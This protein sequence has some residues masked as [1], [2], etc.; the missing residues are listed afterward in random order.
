MLNEHKDTI[1]NDASGALRRARRVVVKVGSALLVDGNGAVNRAWLRKLGEDVAALRA[2]KTDVVI[3]TSG[4]IALG[5]RRLGLSGL[6]RLEESQAAS[7]AGQA[8]L[9]DAWQAAL[10]EHGINVAQVLLTI[11]DTEDRRRYLNARATLETLLRLGAAP[12]INEND[13]VATSEIRYGDN[14]R[15]A[16]HAAQIVGADLLVILSDVDGYYSADPRS[17]PEAEHIP[18]IAAISD[19][20]EQRAGGANKLAGV[21]VGGMATKIAAARIA[22]AN[23]CA[24]VIAKGAVDHPL[25]AVENGAR[26]TL[27]AA[28]GTPDTARKAWIRHRLAPAGKI[29]I[30]DG[31]LGAVKRGASLLAAGVTGVSGDFMSGDAISIV[32]GGATVGQGISALDAADLTRVMGLQSDAV[33]EILGVRRRAAVIDRNDLVLTTRN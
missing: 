17:N 31:A 33:D 10:G 14:D 2:R 16:A 21:G 1:G 3:V 18:F 25:N 32:C 11:Q 28:G 12:V 23:G 26:A 20:I 22:G 6:L 5:R 19:E 27:I 8:A 4:A 15:L 30:D 24:T 9:I 13:T 7:A 29:T